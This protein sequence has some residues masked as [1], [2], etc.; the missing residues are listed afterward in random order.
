MIKYNERVL[1][2]ISDTKG[3]LNDFPQFWNEAL[4]DNTYAN[5]PNLNEMIAY[6]EKIVNN[7]FLKGKSAT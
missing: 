4:I 1:V 6:N 3:V 7:F 2:L 5:T